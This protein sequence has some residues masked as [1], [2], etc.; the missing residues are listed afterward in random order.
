MYGTYHSLLVLSVPVLFSRLHDR[1]TQHR[2]P[3]HQRCWI[4]QLTL[5]HQQVGDQIVLTNDLQTTLKIAP[6]E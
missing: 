1:N 6:Q 3:E 5:V 2:D 4:A